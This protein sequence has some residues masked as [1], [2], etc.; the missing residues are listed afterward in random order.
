MIFIPNPRCARRATARPMRP[1]PMRPSVLPC[2]CVA[3]MCVGRQPVHFPPRTSR[4]PSPARRA[5]ASISVSAR[6]AVSS[7]STSGVFVTTT[8]FAF[9]AATSMLL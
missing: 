2:T 9:A 8:P 1:M 7:V 4:S 5:V 6:S 3:S